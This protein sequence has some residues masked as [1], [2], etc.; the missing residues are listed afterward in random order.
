MSITSLLTGASQ[1]T[2]P[3]TVL[4]PAP[5]KVWWFRIRKKN[6]GNTIWPV[7]LIIQMRSLGNRF[8][9]FIVELPVLWACWTF[10]LRMCGWKWMAQR[11]LEPQ[12]P[13]QEGTQPP[14][15]IQVSAYAAFKLSEAGW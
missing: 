10:L 12:D 1:S 9:P 11:Y 2:S 14:K 3:S 13:M 8:Q 6:G 7:L 4:H 5:V 15:L